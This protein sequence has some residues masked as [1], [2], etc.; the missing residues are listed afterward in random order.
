[1]SERD[2]HNRTQAVP[3]GAPGHVD[4]VVID[5]RY[6]RYRCKHRTCPEREAAR[7]RGEYAYHVVDV[8]THLAW[9]EYEPIPPKR[10]VA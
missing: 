5:G 3:F 8:V 4:F 1:M 7:L 10:R 6:V 2:R 9:F